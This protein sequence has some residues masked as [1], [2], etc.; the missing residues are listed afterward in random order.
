MLSDFDHLL[1][2]V[3]SGVPNRLLFTFDE[4]SHALSLSRAMLR[5]LRRLGRIRVVKIGRSVRVP[6]SEVLR[7][8][9]MGGDFQ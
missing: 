9:G 4:A 7:L 5:K 2:T 1:T 8:C 3:N 6:Q